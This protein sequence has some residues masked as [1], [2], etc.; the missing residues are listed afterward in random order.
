MVTIL[1]R[2]L[3]SKVTR[4]FLL[5]FAVFISLFLIIDFV[6]NV[7]R[8]VN[9]GVSIGLAYVFSRVPLY[10]VRLIPVG[11]LIAIMLTFSELSS[12]SELVAAKSLGI[13][14]FRLS[15]PVFVFAV[16]SCLLSFSIDE[17]LVPPS[18]RISR[19]LCLK[20]AGKTKSFNMGT[21]FWF[22]EGKRTFVYI[23]SFDK[24]KKGACCVSIFKLND[25]FTP[26]ERI[27]AARAINLKGDTWQLEDGTVR[28]L[29]SLESSTFSTRKFN[30]GIGKNDI[31]FIQFDPE[32]FNFFQLASL[33]NGLRQAGYNVLSYLVDLYSK[34]SLPLFPLVVSFIAIPMGVF[35]PREGKRHTL[36]I[37]V[38]IVVLAWIAVSLFDSL[39]RTGLIPPFYASFAPM[40][41]F[42]SVGLILF[43]RVDT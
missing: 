21:S 10:S 22:K 37:G 23:D 20:M 34:L 4:Y 17:L 12:T 3:F 39:G 2:Y 43:S 26:I 38:A 27:D 40:V 6:S 1:D 5:T 41:F 29:N 13:S 19:L 7:D 32:N 25:S 9:N 28:N 16:L 30:L 42:A 11:V 24:V 35:N 36:I 18:S 14:I 33:I 8:F 15:I 31:S